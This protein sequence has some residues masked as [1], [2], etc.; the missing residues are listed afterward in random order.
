MDSTD[1]LN[2]TTL[3]SI[4]KFYSKLQLKNI[5]NDEY[6]HAKKVWEHFE[7]KTLGDYHELYVQADT[8]QLS[9]IFEI[10][11]SLCLKEYQLDPA[12]FVS[13]PSLAFKAMLKITKAKTEL[14]TGID[15]ILMSEKGIRGGLTQ[16]IRKYVVANNKYLPNY[17]K[18]KNST[19]LQYLDA[20]NLYG[21][22][23]NKKLAL[24][25]YK[26]ADKS[27]FTDDFIK[28]Y[29]DE[30]DKGYLI[31]VDV[32]YPKELHSA[33][34]D[35]PVLP[36]KRIKLDKEF[37]H[38]VTKDIKKTHKKVYK[39]FSITHEPENKLIA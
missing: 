39:T 23:M 2:E 7:I 20:N 8:A 29:D 30:G 12:Y 37:E 11:R 35:L 31:Q 25:G 5:T 6:N 33:Y 10:F 9:D 32:E 38:K 27:I 1:K 26:W 16:V 36:E 4:E 34:E 24:N 13:T 19:Y 28:N 21:N 3:P 22:A 14:V 15:M 18:T 17:D